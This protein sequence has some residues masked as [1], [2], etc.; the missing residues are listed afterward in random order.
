[1]TTQKRGGERQRAPK[2]MKADVDRATLSDNANRPVTESPL[3]ARRIAYKAVLAAVVIG[4]VTILALWVLAI[5]QNKNPIVVALTIEPD[6]QVEAESEAKGIQ[7]FR[8]ENRYDPVERQGPA[9]PRQSV[10]LPS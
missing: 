2:K 4:I 8:L 7:V 9:G 10:S 6:N 5:L 3:R 1:M